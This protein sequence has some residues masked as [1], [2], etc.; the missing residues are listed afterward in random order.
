MATMMSKDGKFCRL[1]FLRT[2]LCSYNVVDNQL[3]LVTDGPAGIH[4][5]VGD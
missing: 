4:G 3:T 5:V 1:E 2:S